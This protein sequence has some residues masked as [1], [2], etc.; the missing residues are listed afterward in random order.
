MYTFIAIA[1]LIAIAIIAVAAVGIHKACKR[2]NRKM[3]EKYVH[4]G[5]TIWVRKDLRGLHR[6]HCLCFSCRQ[7]HPGSRGNCP[8]AQTLYQ[9]CIDY[10]VVTPVWECHR[11]RED[12]YTSSRTWNN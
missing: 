10:H 2:P 6:D 3:F 1:V 8:I 7:F 11:F 4:H 9:A 5:K 12:P